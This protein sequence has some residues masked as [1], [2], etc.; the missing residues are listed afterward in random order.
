M[1]D[2][3]QGP[4]GAGASGGDGG[5][6]ARAW[7]RFRGWP[8]WLQVLSWFGL[9][10]VVGAALSS[11]PPTETA[12]ETNTTTSAEAT[13]TTKKR[14][15]TT[16]RST[17][18]TA[19]PTTTTTVPPVPIEVARFQGANDT[20]TDDFEVDGK[21]TLTAE[22]VGGAGVGAEIYDSSGGQ[23]DFISFDPGSHTSKF[24]QGC[25]CYFDISTFGS[26]YTLIVTDI[27]D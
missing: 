17:T 3:P 6:A 21:W 27:P 25:V 18:T 22:V 5:R 19:P 10:L 23:L 24:R 7:R 15:T 16:R 13:T 4:N 26:T 1:A 14:T 2:N 9:F 12:V 20:Q 11:P 8:T